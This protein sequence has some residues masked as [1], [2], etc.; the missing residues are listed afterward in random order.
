MLIEFNIEKLVLT[1][2]PSAHRQKIIK[3][4]KSE[5][6]R[7]FSEGGVRS[8]PTRNFEIQKL[9]GGIIKVNVNAQPG[10]VGQQIARVIH[11]R[12][13]QTMASGDQ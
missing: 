8:F 5:L 6:I 2:M 12:I 4:F 1:G 7:R 10:V 13:N 11:N 9:D 3:E